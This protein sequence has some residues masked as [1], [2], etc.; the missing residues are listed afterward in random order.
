MN[1]EREKAAKVVFFSGLKRLF[2]K[3]RPSIAP[4]VR[5]NLGVV[6]FFFFVCLSLPVE[7]AHPCDYF[8]YF[9]LPQIQAQLKYYTM[10]QIAWRTLL[11]TM[12]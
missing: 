3:H 9:R 4:K 5:N 2:Q 12:D 1:F 8:A 6:Q 11:R 7:F 10:P